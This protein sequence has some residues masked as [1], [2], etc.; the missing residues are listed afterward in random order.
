MAET[1]SDTWSDGVNAG[2]SSSGRRLVALQVGQFA[3][4]GLVALA[5]VGVTTSV[6]SRRVGEREAIADARITTVIRAQGVVTPA[7]TDQ[8]LEHDPAAVSRLDEVVRR[9]VLDDS[10]VRV[11]LW[12]MDG[13]VAY[14][15]EPA[16]IGTKW[17][18]G[19]AERQA[20][21]TGR[22]E[23]E[24][25]DLA[26][27]ENRYEVKYG[28]LLEVY[29][30]VRTP[31]DQVLLF[32]AY[33]R[34][35]LVS[36]NGRRLWRSFAPIAIGALVMLELVQL[37][38]AWSLARRLRQRMRERE[39]LLRRALEA[40]DVERRQIASDLHDSVVQDLAG[41]AFALSAV[42][43][44]EHDAEADGRVIAE[45]AES[46]RGSIRALRSLVVD[47]YP[48][49][50]G[51]VSLESALT[52]LLTRAQDQGVDARLSTDRLRD[53][54]PDHVARLI[55]RVAQ[56]GLRNVL[57]HAGART[58]TVTVG[59]AGADAFVEVADDGRGFDSTR[60][61]ERQASGHM[62]LTALRGLVSDAGGSLVITAEPGAGTVL[63]ATVPVR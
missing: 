52:D 11:K 9:D 13:V 49:N 20:M 37:P 57:D 55:Y 12:T 10:L 19:L 45:S 56:E 27:P 62:G 40:S 41:V 46:V 30:P 53:P 17:A 48:P 32:E 43:R 63:R 4:A 39:A 36:S 50:F 51:E 42:G 5:I 7:L 35:G 24:V 22:I 28:K 31:S 44:R 15:D 29:L 61:A 58:L 2:T 1:E 25:S 59:S 33:Y 8:L 16:L 23:A 54:L 47:I 34:Y 14:S 26:K 60:M 38:L 3:L 6:A 21:S 18:L